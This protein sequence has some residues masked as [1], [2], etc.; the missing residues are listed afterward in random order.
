MTKQRKRRH[1]SGT[2]EK[3]EDEAALSDA[4]VDFKSFV[5]TKTSDAVDDIKKTVDQRMTSIE[6]SLSFAYESITAASNKA[7]AAEKNIETVKGELERLKHRV[8]Q[9][10]EER[11][12]GE[13]LNRIPALIF[14]GQDLHLPDQDSRLMTV[15]VAVIDRLL[16]LDVR[17]GQIVGVRRLPRDRIL[18]KFASSERGSLRDLVFRKK[19]QA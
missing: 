2:P 8:K 14:S 13:R 17:P 3:G 19:K 10:E 12:K 5:E 4:V 16:E 11:E 15:A 6:D 7:S 18:V 1:E 9:L